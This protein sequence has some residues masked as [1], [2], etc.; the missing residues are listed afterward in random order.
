MVR[1]LSSRENFDARIAAC[2]V[3]TE[4]VL[5]ELLSDRPRPE[6]VVRPPLLM[7]ALRYAVLGG[8]K[9]F[10]PFLVAETAAVFGIHSEG[11]I[12]AGA[13]LELIHCY[14]LIHD[15][16]PAMDDDDLRRGKP[17]LHKVHDDAM[18]VLAG[19]ALLTLAFDVLTD[20]ATTPGAVKQAALVRALARG[21][22]IGGMVG[23]QLLDL[24]AEGR[25]PPDAAHPTGEAGVIRIQSMKTGA[26]IRT[27]CRMGAILGEAK[28]DDV[29][30]LDAYAD[31]LGLAFQI[32]DDLLD[33]EGDS[34]TL[35]K[36]AGKD[37]AAGKATFVSLHGIEGA[38]RRLDE[39]T[40]VGER[41]LK[42]FGGRGAVLK[43]L[44]AFNSRRTS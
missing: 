5:A 25:Y 14:S 15:D 31:A 35:G 28:A 22:G 4:R 9:R 20:S 11:P 3:A 7:E 32:K 6:E 1:K 36:A 38:R 27:A 26:L 44:L 21:A 37:A 41:A 30:A 24:A 8:G 33:A 16:L 12:R 29:K 10:R 23:G 17:T 2:A 42:H 19:D 13:A 43:E 39:V 40:Q 18:A 34:A